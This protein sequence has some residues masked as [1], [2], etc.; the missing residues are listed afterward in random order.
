MAFAGSPTSA[1]AALPAYSGPRRAVEM[2]ETAAM[3]MMY[4]ASNV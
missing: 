1:A 4:T 3:K 2:S